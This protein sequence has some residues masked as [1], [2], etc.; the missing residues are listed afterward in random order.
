[1]AE[2]NPPSDSA[3][4]DGDRFSLLAFVLGEVRS[5]PLP[6]KGS[7]TLGRGEACHIR[8][9]EP[10][11][12][13]R[14]AT[15]HVGTSFTLEDHG[16]VNGTRL[17]VSRERGG[18]TGSIEEIRLLSGSP[19]T[20]EPFTPV[21]LGSVVIVIQPVSAPLTSNGQGAAP[22]PVVSDP[23]M[24][25]LYELA[26]LVAQSPI[27]VLLLG[28]TGVGKELLAETIHLRSQRAKGPFVPINCAAFSESL[29]ESELFGYE[30]GAFTGAV[31]TKPGLIERAHGGTL[32]LDEVGEMPLSLQV[33]LLRV[34]EDLKVLRVGG[35]E[36]QS[37]DVRF[38]AATHQ[39]LD[40][41]VARGT[42]RKDLYFRINGF[43]LNIPPLRERVGEIASLARY[44]I[45]R[46]TAENKRSAPG[47]TP[48]AQSLLERHSWPGNIRELRNI[49]GRAL[50]LCR[51]EA[52]QPEHL[53]FDSAPKVLEPAPKVLEPA[54]KELEPT[55]P[56]S[57]ALSSAPAS[58]TLGEDIAALERQRILEAL[59]QCA[60]NQTRAAQV[61]GISRR[62]LVTRL[63]MYGIP[64]PRPRSR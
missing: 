31:R 57:P 20:I 55:S 46:S 53:V 18:G 5:Y 52:I 27:S 35:L 51:G 4:P 44:F 64:G 28:E 60:G 16:S 43:T 58:G 39:D 56:G 54:P 33:K 13:R 10:S 11:V 15:L 45:E 24:Q 41:C 37:V 23:S 26:S 59:E 19:M 42:F 38:V 48:E 25:R 21:Q 9:E 61:L 47:L 36:P 62:T 3:G 7:I 17:R 2:R 34:L 1:M 14:H 49:M 63:K 6:P 12:S 8:I 22:Q 50:V 30:R 29:L 40:A 32:F